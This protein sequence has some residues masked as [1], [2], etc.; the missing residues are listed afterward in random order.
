MQ[1]IN[2]RNQTTTDDQRKRPRHQSNTIIIKDWWV[3]KRIRL[4][5]SA[6]KGCVVLKMCPGL[7][8]LCESLGIE[9]EDM[10][11]EFVGIPTVKDIVE[12]QEP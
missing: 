7:R 1:Q 3:G 4:L 11:L 10:T 5:A 8:T 2:C 6:Q 12:A 9:L